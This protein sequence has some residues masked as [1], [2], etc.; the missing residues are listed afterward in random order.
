[1]TTALLDWLAHHSHIF[2]IGNESFR[3]RASSAALK[4]RKD[5]SPGESIACTA[6]HTFH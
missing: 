3:F 6:R 4:T 5:K 2:E 1:M